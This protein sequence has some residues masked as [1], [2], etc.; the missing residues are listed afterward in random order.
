MKPGVFMPWNLVRASE[1]F[2]KRRRR[3]VTSKDAP[4]Q[5]V[6]EVCFRVKGTDTLPGVGIGVALSTWSDTRELMLAV[7]QAVERWVES[8]GGQDG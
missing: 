2:A 3:A 7:R 1:A 5:V 8:K 6:V 4:G